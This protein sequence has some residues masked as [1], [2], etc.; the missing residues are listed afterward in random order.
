MT[1]TERVE[2]L[3]GE[4]EARWP[5]GSLTSV[6]RCTSTLRSQRPSSHDPEEDL[7]RGPRCTK[8]GPKGPRR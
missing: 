1:I 4:I 2:G 8:G 6:A 5:D 3:K 7:R